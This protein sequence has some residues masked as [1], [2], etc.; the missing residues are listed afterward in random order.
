M[1]EKV[2]SNH[3]GATT[4]IEGIT[5]VCTMP[6]D[7]AGLPHCEFGQVAGEFRYELS[8]WLEREEQPAGTPH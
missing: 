8:W 3:C 5:F 4:A 1:D 6:E 7:H 2:E